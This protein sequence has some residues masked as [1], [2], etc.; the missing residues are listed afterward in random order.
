MDSVAAL[1]FIA[2]L[3]YLLDDM[4]DPAEDCEETI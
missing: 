1:F 4:V 3:L 2:A